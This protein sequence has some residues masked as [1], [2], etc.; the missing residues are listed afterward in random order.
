M[1]FPVLANVMLK[2]FILGSSL[3]SGGTN[4][5]GQILTALFIL[6]GLDGHIN[7]LQSYHN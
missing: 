4:L 3:V 2:I 5:N 6:H 7:I 1:Y